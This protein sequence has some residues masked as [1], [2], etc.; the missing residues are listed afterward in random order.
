MF[1][2]DRGPV[3][4]AA[5]LVFAFFSMPGASQEAE[6]ELVLVAGATGGTGSLVVTRLR[7]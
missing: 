6:G 4:L 1:K 5:L 7:G 3:S 2:I